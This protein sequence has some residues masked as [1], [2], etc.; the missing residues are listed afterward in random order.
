M[1]N[2]V[3]KFLIDGKEYLA[4]NGTFI[5]DVAR[6][7]GIFIPTLCNIP[8]I[9]PRGSCRMCTVSVN[10]RYMSACTT[11]ISEGMDVR[12]NT[13]DL[14][15]LRKAIL[16]I[17]FVEGNHICP[18]CEKSGNCDLQALGYRYQI[19]VSR[20]P[21]QYPKRTIDALNP[22]LIKDH[23]RCI[24]CKRC[25]R[26]IKDEQGRGFFAFHK[27]GHKIEISIDHSMNELLTEEVA[28]RAVD[29]CPTGAL[30]KKESGYQTPISNRK[31]ERTPIGSD[32]E[33]AHQ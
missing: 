24:L 27:R 4:K 25:I 23:N 5:I 10:G 21:H 19:L 14:I 28:Q 1:T 3:I 17:M 13:P 32:I 30:L 9:K 20:F 33:H 18:V 31:Y 15:D 16:E 7:S 29:I 22:H 6:E 2:N 8:G 12:T 11:P 26:T